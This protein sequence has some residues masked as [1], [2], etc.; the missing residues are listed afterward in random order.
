M[1]QRMYFLG[2]LASLVAST[3]L[4]A[5]LSAAQIVEKNVAARGGL[6]AWRAVNTLTLAGQ[7]DA[8]GKPNVQLPFVLNMKRPHKS[9][10]EISIKDQASAVQT[11]DGKQGWK[12]R[13]YL[14]REDAEPFTPSEAKAAAETAE[15]DGPLVDYEKKGTKVELLGTE[16]V[17]G[18][19]AYKL[20]LTQAGGQHFN[21]WVDATTFLEV[22]IDGSP[23]KLDSKVHK[24]AIFYRDFKTVNGLQIPM[25]LETVTEGVKDTRKMSFRTVAVNPPLDDKLFGK[26][27]LA[28]AQ[29]VTR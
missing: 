5:E 22:K 19:K 1:K 20:G 3:A 18:T 17:A 4:A 10:L 27:Q 29:A 23:R 11:F 26:P 16:M 7:M 6:E 13:P 25:V 8:G 14:N 21:L 12:L 9:R 24:V 15:L 2:A 28:V